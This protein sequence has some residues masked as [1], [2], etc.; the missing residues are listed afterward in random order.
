MHA[1]RPQGWTSK[2]SFFLVD[3]VIMQKCIVT[4]LRSTWNWIGLHNTLTL[5]R[6]YKLHGNGKNLIIMVMAFHLQ[7]EVLLIMSLTITF[8]VLREFASSFVILTCVFDVQWVNNDNVFSCTIHLT[9]ALSP[10]NMQ[11]WK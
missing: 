5:R 10:N 4:L 9:R 6:A 11:L 3:L 8:F 1:K 2:W 7:S